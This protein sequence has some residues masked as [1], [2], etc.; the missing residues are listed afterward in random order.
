MFRKCEN[1]ERVHFLFDHSS[2][3]FKFTRERFGF[4]KINF[5]VWFWFLIECLEQRYEFGQN[6]M[7]F[8]NSEMLASSLLEKGLVFTRF[9]PHIWVDQA[10]LDHVGN[11][12]TVSL[13]VGQWIN[14]PGKYGKKNI[15]RPLNYYLHIA[16]KS[17]FHLFNKAVGPGKKSKINKHRAYVLES[18]DPWWVWY[19]T[20]LN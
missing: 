11:T 12:N 6:Y 16:Q 13:D 2:V 17:T 1:A 8:E 20:W 5:R 7:S 3:A 4:I 14:G 19:Q 15:H 9:E 18:R 10:G